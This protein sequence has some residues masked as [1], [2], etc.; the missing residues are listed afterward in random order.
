MTQD[1]VR[2]AAMQRAIAMLRKFIFSGDSRRKAQA[3]LPASRYRSAILPAALLFASVGF[4]TGCHSTFVQATIVN[5]SGT[6]LRLVEVDYPSASFGTT[7]LNNAA[8]YHYRFK[9]QGSGTV[10][11]NFVDATGKAHHAV[12]PELDEGQEGTLLVTIDESHNVSWTPSFPVN[13]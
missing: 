12:G 9:I 3:L 8:E 13:K 5:H 4:L 1:N 10:K 6:P 11:L 2:V 7:N